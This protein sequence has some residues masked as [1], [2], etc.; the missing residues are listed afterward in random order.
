M[1][2]LTLMWHKY[3]TPTAQRLQEDNLNNRKTS[4]VEEVETDLIGNSIRTR[5]TKIRS[6]TR[7]VQTNTRWILTDLNNTTLSSTVN[8][9]R[10]GHLN[11][12]VVEADSGHH[13]HKGNF[14]KESQITAP[15]SITLITGEAVEETSEVIIEVI[16]VE[17]ALITVLTG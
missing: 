12:G 6:P 11:R 14:S 3:Q 15:D 8:S 5:D 13:S 10:I 4:K 1:H 17:G 2:V 9:N 7:I 16:G